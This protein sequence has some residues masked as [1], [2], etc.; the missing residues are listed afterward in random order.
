M[1]LTETQ[2]EARRIL[3]A[4]EGKW[5]LHYKKAG[6]DLCNKVFNHTTAYVMDNGKFKAIKFA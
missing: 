4:L 6:V 5:M 1:P 3:A 2:N